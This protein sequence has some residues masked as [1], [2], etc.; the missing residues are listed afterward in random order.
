MI[1]GLI[2]INKP[3]NISSHSIV[4]NIRKLFNTKKVGHF[5]TLD[6][7]AEGLLLVGIGK[8]T[9]FFDFY[10]KKKK[11]YS[12]I[13]KFGFSTSTYDMEGIPTS[14]KKEID[15]TKIDVNS[16]LLNFTGEILQV[17]PI[18]SAKKYKGKPSYKYARENK[19]IELKPVKV[20]VYS[21]KGEIVNKNRLYFE[22]L[23]SSGTY[24]RSIA[25]D[26]GQ[27][28]GVGAYLEELKRERIGEFELDKSVSI[29]ELVKSNNFMNITDFVIPIEKLLPEFSKIIV[30]Q[31]GRSAVLNG[32]PLLAKDVIKIFPSE[33]DI[34][35]RLFD[36]HGKLLSISQK[37]ENKT[38]F[39]SK[40]V[41]PD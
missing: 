1:S 5:G 7:M 34:Y 16:F 4:E 28:I 33:S 19:K 32:M 41:F 40:I 23:T 37:E 27:K 6:P 11:L 17:P 39:K 36:E 30:N 12:G 2:A 18:Y 20:N 29:E 25:H 15:L 24:V 9:R 31:M 26:L 21:L 8:A 3:K 22:A 35:F 13:I 38:R 10:M 14:K